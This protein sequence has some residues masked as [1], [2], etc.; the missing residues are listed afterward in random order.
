VPVGSRVKGFRNPG[1]LSVK[2]YGPLPKE[3]SG[4]LNP[5]LIVI[6]LVLVLITQVGV[7]GNPWKPEH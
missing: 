4:T 1:M 7:V 6:V 3:V 2:E 5:L